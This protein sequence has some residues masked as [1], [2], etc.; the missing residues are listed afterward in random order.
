MSKLSEGTPGLTCARLWTASLARLCV[1]TTD[2]SSTAGL[3]CSESD[4]G[5]STGAAS[6]TT[7]KASGSGDA[8]D[9]SLDSIGSSGAYRRRQLVL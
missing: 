1:Q 2:D 3:S 9:P 5:V 6:S 8:V 4:D 7:G